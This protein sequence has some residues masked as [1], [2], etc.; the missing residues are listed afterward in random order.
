MGRTGF[1]EMWLVKM[2]GEC[3]GVRSAS[4]ERVGRGV[5]WGLVHRGGNGYLK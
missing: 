4:Q 5:D 3:W 2:P 1:R